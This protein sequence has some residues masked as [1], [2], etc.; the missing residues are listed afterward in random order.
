MRLGLVGTVLVLLVL[1]AVLQNVAIGSV[2]GL[3]LLILV[4]LLLTG[5]L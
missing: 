1:A 4:L 5:R 2:G 3:L